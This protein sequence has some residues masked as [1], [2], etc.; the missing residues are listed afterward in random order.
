MEV[1]CEEPYNIKAMT[2][3]EVGVYHDSVALK[4]VFAVQEKIRISVS[5]G[6]QHR[7]TL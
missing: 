6:N 5:F 2:V 4:N 7:G 3:L 1:G